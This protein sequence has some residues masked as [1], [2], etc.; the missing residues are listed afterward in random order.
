MVSLDSFVISNISISEPIN[1]QISASFPSSMT[2]SLFAGKS[3][4]TP[5]TAAD[6]NYL[7][8]KKKYFNSL[9]MLRPE[10][11][12]VTLVRSNSVQIRSGNS[13]PIPIPRTISAT[14]ETTVQFVPPHLL[15]ENVSTAIINSLPKKPRSTYS[16]YYS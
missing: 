6:R 10:A 5:E 7:D 15:S 14:G 13:T 3:T 8:I 12:Q 2:C 16:E 1:P 11:K 9:Q 4:S